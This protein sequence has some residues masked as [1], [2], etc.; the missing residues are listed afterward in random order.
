MWVGS[1]AWT[2]RRTCTP[3]GKD[4]R[5]RTARGDADEGEKKTFVSFSEV[6][7]TKAGGAAKFTVIESSIAFIERVVS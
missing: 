2:S 3:K 5:K 4:E 6:I 7:G 1:P